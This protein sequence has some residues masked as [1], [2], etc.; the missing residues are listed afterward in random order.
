MVEYKRFDFAGIKRIEIPKTDIDFVDSNNAKTIIEKYLP[1]ILAEHS[2]N[3]QK[4]D[5]LYHYYLGRQDI[6]K[7]ER[8]HNKD[9]D[10]NSIIIEN[11]AKRQVDFNS[12][13]ITGE[14]REY[15]HKSD[16]NSDDLMYLGRYFADCD[17]F[18]K[19]K[20]LKTWVFSTG[21]GVTYTAP[22]IDIIIAD[23]KDAVTGLPK[24]RYKTAQEGFDIKYNAPFV[25][26][27]IDPRNNFVVYSSGFDKEPLFCVS[28]VDVEIEQNS[29]LM[30]I[31]GKQIHIETKYAS[32]V[33]KSDSKFS[34]FYSF[35][36]YGEKLKLIVEK[37][38]NY[39]PIIEYSVNSARMG[40]VE[41]NRDIFNEIN[42]LKSNVSDMITEK[43]NPIFVFKNTDIEAKDLPEMFR[44]GALRIKDSATTKANSSADVYTIATDIPFSELSAYYEQLITAS[45]DISGTPLASGQVTSGGDT[46]Q[47]R[48]LGGG[49]NNTYIISNSNI[50]SLKAYDYQEL[51]LILQICKSIPN[52]PIN[53]LHAS[54][55]DIKYRINQSDNILAKAQAMM[56]LY[57]MN[58]PKEEIL[59]IVPV[60]SDITTVSDK[61]ETKD[62]LA[63]RIAKVQETT[64]KNAVVEMPSLELTDNGSQE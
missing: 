23:G 43:A 48:L 10:N 56:N 62:E 55:V 18:S 53:E 14:Q 47:A 26:N 49:W 9:K 46:G 45:D 7:K 63:N 42:L 8:L 38:L 35:G 60:A 15:S 31:L 37:N 19:D 20:E 25:F 22:R 58:M 16:S 13:F 17:F 61:W 24:V 30:P 11:H 54:Q 59:K 27:C 34:K 3:S 4:I 57:S 2:I 52:C 1:S 51:K 64:T 44:A 39:L 29:D 12:G 32:F 28:I 40:I 50:A 6:L 5:Y 36:L 33:A 41:T 21:I